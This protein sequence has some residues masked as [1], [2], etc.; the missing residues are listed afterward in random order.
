MT[1]DQRHN[2][3]SATTNGYTVDRW[4]YFGSQASK[5]VWGQTL[6][7]GSLTQF[8][9]SLAFTSSS[10]YALLASDYFIFY[11]PIEG[12]NVN[13]FAW[14]TPQAQPVTLTFWAFSSISGTFGGAVTNYAG[15]RSYPFSYALV[16]NIWTKITIVIPGDTAG[17]WVMTGSAGSLDVMFD[18]GSGASHRG[19]ANNWASANYFGATGTVSVVSVNA[20]NF[21]VTGVKLEIGNAATQFARQSIQK[22]LSDCQR[23][24]QVF[25][26]FLQPYSYAGAAGISLQAIIYSMPV[27]MRATPTILGA[28]FANGTNIQAGSAS[29]VPTNNGVVCQFTSNAVGG[30]W[31]QAT[32]TALNAEL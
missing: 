26:G 1:I 22:S 32:F 3:N 14:G 12:Y 29:L 9:Y 27:S 10:A 6:S 4:Q 15:T 23:Y 5:G 16:S 7:G 31:T 25:G 13:D 17:T 28:V 30:F 19:P 24:Y 11:Q 8:Y 20:A 21:Y 2:G 18:L